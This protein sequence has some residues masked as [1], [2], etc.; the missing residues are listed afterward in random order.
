MIHNVSNIWRVYAEFPENSLRC[1]LKVYPRLGRLGEDVLCCE[2]R[3]LDFRPTF[4]SVDKLPA[5]SYPEI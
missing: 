2:N 1:K 5:L 3:S 4:V